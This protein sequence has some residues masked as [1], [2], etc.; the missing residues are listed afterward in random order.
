MCVVSVSSS[1][2]PG[3]ILPSSVHLYFS[4]GLLMSLLNSVH[5][6]LGKF[7]EDGSVLGRGPGVSP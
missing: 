1:L 7:L 6:R 2:L 5:E 3:M 4:P